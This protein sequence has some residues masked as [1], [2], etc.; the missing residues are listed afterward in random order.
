MVAGVI[1]TITHTRRPLWLKLLQP[2]AV[3]FFDDWIRSEE[4]YIEQLRRGGIYTEEMIQIRER[5]LQPIR[6]LLGWWQ[7]A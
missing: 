1:S 4:R 6:A 5:N 7:G 3:W 2:L